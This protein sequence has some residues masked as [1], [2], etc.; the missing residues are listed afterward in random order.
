M[1]FILYTL[2]AAV[3]VIIILLFLIPKESR[4]KI[5]K[6]VGLTG[7]I[8]GFIGLGIGLFVFFFFDAIHIVIL[9]LGAI[10]FGVLL[11]V[12]AVASESGKFSPSPLTFLSEADWIFLWEHHVFTGFVGLLFF[13]SLAAF[14]ISIKLTIFWWLERAIDNAKKTSD[15]S[16]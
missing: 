4:E 12:I 6:Y 3:L 15:G 2:I 10:L 1:N 8:V 16:D 5:E 13:F 7:R 14:F 11:F 9:F